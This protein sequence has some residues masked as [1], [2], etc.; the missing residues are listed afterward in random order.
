MWRA[1]REL[2]D[3]TLFK[4]RRGDPVALEAMV[5]HYANPIHA[6]VRRLAPAARVDD[7][8]QEVVIKVVAAVPSFDPAGP[9]RLSTWILTI[10][11]RHLIDE[12]RKKTRAE[13]PLDEAFDEPSL[14]PGP[15]ALLL[16]ME[17]RQALEF[18]VRALPDAYRRVFILAVIH[19][20]P[21]DAVAQAEGI[22]LG[23][24]KSR[25]HR[26]RAALAH[27]LGPLLDR[28]QQARSLS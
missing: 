26:A 21:L 17:A 2:D 9:A 19:D 28:P 4:A 5:R 6:L 22:P 7:L 27:R 12:S 13:G 24:V 3:V 23:T 10:A 18:A 8:C 16:Q 15:D 11:H 20:Q 14:E 25:L 1:M